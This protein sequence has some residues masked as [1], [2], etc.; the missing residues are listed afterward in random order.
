[1]TA[2]QEEIVPL[3]SLKFLAHPFLNPREYAAKFFKP[4]SYLLVLHTHGKAE[5]NHYH[6]HGELVQNLTQRK[7]TDLFRTHPLKE[8]HPNQ[9]PSSMKGPYTNDLGFQYCLKEVHLHDTIDETV[10]TVPDFVE[11]K[12]EW[13]TELN[14]ASTEYVE[15]KIE[16]FNALLDPIPLGLEPS[17]YHGRAVRACLTDLYASGKQANHAFTHKVRRAVWQKSARFHPYISSLYK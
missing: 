17:D 4:G 13:V 14:E 5:K 16:K 3:H 8:Q 6:A 15:D 1:M 11:N 9:R 7:K 2:T 10:L 12:Y